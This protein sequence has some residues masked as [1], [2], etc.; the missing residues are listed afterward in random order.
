MVAKITFTEDEKSDILKYHNNGKSAREIAGIF[1]IGS[2]TMSRFIKNELN[3]SVR[4]VVPKIGDI[5]NGWEIIDIFVNLEKEPDGKK[6][7][8]IRN[9]ENGGD[10]I[11]EIRL[12]NLTNGLIG[13]ANIYENGEIKNRKMSIRNTSHGKFN[14]KIY[15][16]WISIKHSRYNK[17]PTI[18]QLEW[19]DF[20]NFEK[21]A[22][23]NGYIDGY[24]LYRKILINGY[25]SDNCFISE[26]KIERKNK[27]FASKKI[28]RKKIRPF[29]HY[30]TKIKSTTAHRNKRRKIN[31]CVNLTYEDLI[32]IIP[33]NGIGEC[34]YC[35]EKL[36][37]IDYQ[38]RKADKRREG[39]NFDRKDNNDG[40]SADN[41]VHCCGN[42]NKTRSD[43]FTYEEFMLLSPVLKQIR[44]DRKNNYN[45][46]EDGI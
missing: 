3:I 26:T 46:K 41:I 19:N 25:T 2:C 27:N 21:W 35:D 1:N 17:T 31:L 44:I 18:L 42:C 16:I 38:D 32:K 22:I 20:N 4:K 23:D 9:T 15:K 7:A 24:F 36:F 43:K 40:Y 14:T 6:I 12:T 34:H 11:R 5:L 37:W 39:S 10:V 29:E 8:K 28:C 33:Y 45:L 13:S 30:L